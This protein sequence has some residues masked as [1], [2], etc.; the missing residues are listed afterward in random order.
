ME[1]CNITSLLQQS[2]RSATKESDRTFWTT[3]DS[4]FLS[5]R[6]TTLFSV[7]RPSNQSVPH[8]APVQGYSDSLQWQPKEGTEILV[9]DRHALE[10]S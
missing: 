6:A 1:K 9:F 5:W 4:W 3:D 7:F 8:V 2:P 10:I